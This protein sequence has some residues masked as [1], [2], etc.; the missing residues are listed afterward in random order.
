MNMWQFSLM[1]VSFGFHN[2][3]FYCHSC[4]DVSFSESLSTGL[5][6]LART[7]LTWPCMQWISDVCSEYLSA[8]NKGMQQKQNGSGNLIHHA[9]THGE[10]LKP[11]PCLHSNSERHCCW[12]AHGLQI[13]QILTYGS[14]HFQAFLMSLISEKEAHVTMQTSLVWAQPAQWQWYKLWETALWQQIWNWSLKFTRRQIH[15][16]LAKKKKGSFLKILG[17]CILS[18]CKLLHPSQNHLS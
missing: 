15:M 13:L 5:D 1:M 7:L 12:K 2:D 3:L 10:C 17:M 18:W 4:L 9:S 14:Q 8:T 16:D 11:E 6:H